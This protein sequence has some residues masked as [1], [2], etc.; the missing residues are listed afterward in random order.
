MD[1]DHSELKSFAQKLGFGYKKIWEA[2]YPS[3]LHVYIHEICAPERYVINISVKIGLRSSPVH[4]K[5]KL[6]MIKKITTT[7]FNWQ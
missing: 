1:T 6:Q 4:I 5:L 7:L 2:S 3:L